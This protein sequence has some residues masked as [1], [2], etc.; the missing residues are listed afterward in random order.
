MNAS[1]RLNTCKS[2]GNRVAIPLTSGARVRNAYATYLQLGDSPSKEG[3][4]PHSNQI[5]HDIWFKAPAVED[6]H[7]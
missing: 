5:S 6:G 4:I 3:L 1:G 2:N 7:A